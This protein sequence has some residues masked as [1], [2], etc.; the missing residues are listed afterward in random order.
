MSA[1]TRAI[2]AVASLCLCAC[3]TDAAPPSSPSSSA[4][5]APRLGADVAARVGAIEIPV[6]SLARIA[7][8]QQIPPARARDLAVRDALFASE[9]RA[10]GLDE[11]PEVRSA[12]SAVLARRLLHELHEAAAGAGPVTDEELRIAT[13][14][15][16]LELDRPEG[17]RTVHAVVRLAADADAATRDKAVALAGAIRE[18]VSPAREIALRTTPPD[19]PLGSTQPPAD[20]AVEAFVSAARS[21]PAEG[22][23]VVAQPLPPVSATGRTLSPEPRQFDADFARAAVS[24]VARGDLSA[25]VTS[26][27][28]VHVIMLLERI[29]AR[30]VPAEE[31]RR[32]VRD[33]VVADRAR[34]AHTKLTES[35]RREARVVGGLDAALEL[36]RIEP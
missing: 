30:V 36:L 18:A 34:A 26:S 31:R 21:V 33:E 35:L 27:F 23:E 16:W 12:I 2:A 6:D 1:L 11:A 22:L 15:H 13:E 20:P 9:A 25:P 10:R 19:V 5:E 8:A 7:A 3:G 4:R 17:F 24:L 14:R 29:P 28:G 32:L